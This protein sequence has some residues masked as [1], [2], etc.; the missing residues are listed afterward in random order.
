MGQSLWSFLYNSV[1]VIASPFSPFLFF[2]LYSKEKYRTQLPLRLG[3]VKEIKDIRRPVIWIHALS[4]GEVNAAFPFIKEVRKN[5]QDA[6]LLLTSTTKTGLDALRK[7]AKTLSKPYHIT[8]MPFDVLPIIKR[9]LNTY[10]PDCFVLV[11]TDVWPNL[12]WELKRRNIPSFLASGSISSK[13][14]S[15]S[16]LISSFFK[17]LYN[18]FTVISMQSEDDKKRLSQTGIDPDKLMCLGNFK[19]DIPL[20]DI[21]K[22]KKNAIKKR[23]NIEEDKLVFVAGSTHKGEEEI[24]LETFSKLKGHINNLKLIIAP[25]DI[26]RSKEIETL[27]DKFGFS[28]QLRTQIEKSS[29]T[30]NDILLIDTFGELIDCY[31]ISDLAFVGGSLVP[32]GGHNLF[33]PASCGVGV[34]FGPYIESCKDMAGLLLDKRAGLMIDKENIFDNT[35]E[36]LSNRDR[37]SYMGKMAYKVVSDVGGAIKR[38]ILVLDKILNKKQLR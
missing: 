7:R 3:R 12:I 29:N 26:K 33:E 17:E 22:E 9:F 5:W 27:I 25:R 21:S 18:A 16:K 36:L 32:I 13:S 8:A 19:F 20:K 6:T 11:E 14:V 4:L 37:L 2:Y 31:L 38:H 23:Y 35:L 10:N 34:L 1:Q 30:K 15:R 24:I 28:Y